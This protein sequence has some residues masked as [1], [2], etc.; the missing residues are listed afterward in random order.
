METTK[1]RLSKNYEYYDLASM[2][3]CFTRKY[4]RV[5]CTAI[6]RMA[7]TLPCQLFIFTAVSQEHFI[8]ISV[9]RKHSRNVDN[10]L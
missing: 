8:M 1:R 9:I 2:N 7:I 6:G 5:V 3:K 4:Y 10:N